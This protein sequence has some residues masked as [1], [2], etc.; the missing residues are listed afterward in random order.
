MGHYLN[1]AH[2]IRGPVLSHQARKNLSMIW[3]CW[4]WEFTSQVYCRNHSW[5]WVVALDLWSAM[6]CTEAIIPIGFQPMT[7]YSRETEAYLFLGDRSSSD[8]QLWL[9]DS[10][11][12]MLKSTAVWTLPMQASFLP[13]SQGQ[14]AHSPMAFHTSSGSSGFFLHRYFPP[15]KCLPI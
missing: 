14:M 4:S 7:D 13:F 6:H 10:H 8:G 1:T 5:S 11:S 9:K 2:D 15:V 3:I 12:A